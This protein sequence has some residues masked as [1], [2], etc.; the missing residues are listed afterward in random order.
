MTQTS[1]K[2]KD[3]FRAMIYTDAK[4]VEWRR[5]MDGWFSDMGKDIYLIRHE[6]MAEVI[7]RE[8]NNHEN[9]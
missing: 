6:E 8:S 1:P 5:G 2:V 9:N 3:V 4:G 7:D